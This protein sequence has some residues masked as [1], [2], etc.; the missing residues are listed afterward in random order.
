M[1][2]MN[3][4][5]LYVI[6]DLH[7]GGDY[8]QGPERGGRG[9][10]ICTHVPELAAFVR[11]VAAEAHEA[12]VE[13]VINGDVIDFLAE[14]RQVADP[15]SGEMSSGWH[16]FIDDPVEA[17]KILR[18][19][20]ERD[21]DFFV[22]LKQLLAAGAR[23]TLTLGNH[24][25]ELSFPSL[26]R[27]L[28]QELEADGKRFSFIYD[29][30]AYQVGNVLIEHGNRYDEWNVVSYDELRRARSVQ[31]RKEPV[32]DAA[33]GFEAPAGS[34]LVAGIMNEIKTRYPFIDL[35]KPENEA[36]IPILLALAPEYRARIVTI[37]GLVAKS[38]RHRIGSDGMPLYAG[39]I[40]DVLSERSGETLVNEIV[41]SRIGAADM[42]GFE[43]IS[44]AG[45]VS[46][47]RYQDMAGDIASSSLRSLWS[48]LKLTLASPSEPV[49]SRLPTLLAALK[50][51]EED[52][53]FEPN[54]EKPQYLDAAQRILSRGF[55]VV[56]FGHTHLAK[57]I[58]LEN[59]TYFNTG[60]WADVIPFPTTILHPGQSAQT[61]GDA[62]VLARL[63][64][65]VG[66]M[67][68]VR[69][70]E[71]LRFFPK[72]VR[73]ELG[74]DGRVVSSELREYKGAGLAS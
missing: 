11:A 33:R 2:M 60:T 19:I 41:R 16:P 35:L 65:F 66:D 58:T 38:Q 71:Y 55:D 3:P 42:P 64:Q 69:L 4:K 15:V 13:L 43:T 37:A 6:S 48:I 7:L 39:D 30:E 27:M 20:I 70:A 57:S 36:A 46:T 74:D 21:K 17:G 5:R 51:T 18:R 28:A 8:A 61:E 53:S 22:A 56:L 52:Y 29:G 68:G 72:Y 9:F 44:G 12:D 34:F 67:A 1:S 14:T 24:D 10:R 50:G 62:A 45:K 54:R 23:L 25:I 73:I 32:L 26:R 40:A 31:S 63:E 47:D 49:A 59:G